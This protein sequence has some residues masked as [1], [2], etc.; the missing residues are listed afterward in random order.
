M[1]QPLPIRPEEPFPAAAVGLLIAGLALAAFGGVIMKELSGV[2][3]ALLIVWSRNVT[4]VL[5][6]LPF[7]LVRYGA[8]IFMPPRPELQLLRA[9]LLFAG[10]TC[11]IVGVRDLPLADAIAILY[12]YP[13]VMTAL[14]PLILKEQVGTASWVGV[15]GGFLGVLVVMRPEFT[16]AALPSFLVLAAGTLMGL[17]LLLTR[18]IVRAGNPLITATYTGLAMIALTSVPLPFFWHA[19]E[20]WQALLMIALGA[21]T[22]LSQWLSILAL[23]RAPVPILSPFS[24]AEIPVAVAFGLI[25]FGDFPDLPAWTGIAVII[26]SGAMVA[27]SGWRALPPLRRA[28]P[29]P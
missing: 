17:Q 25:F 8:G 16:G 7:A 23:S 24:Y 20:A 3:A 15:I 19:V 6:L 28:P 29:G 18:M 12:V 2:V 4:Y 26:A 10:T 21:V 11:F 14:A 22:A 13:F 5:V 9:L 27:R 1:Q